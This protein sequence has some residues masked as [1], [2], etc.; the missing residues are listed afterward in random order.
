M[1]NL[2]Q[3]YQEVSHAI[4]PLLNEADSREMVVLTIEPALPCF[5]CG[6]PA[7]KALVAPSPRQSPED[8][9]PWLTF[10]ICQRCEAAQ[11]GDQGI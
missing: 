8:V 7:H 10:P 11:I 3:K 5:L 2:P 1:T 9:T 6:N 4:I